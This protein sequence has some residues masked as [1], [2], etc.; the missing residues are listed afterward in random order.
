MGT[1][2]LLRLSECLKALAPF[3][4]MADEFEG[5]APDRL[6]YAISSDGKTF[7][8]TVGHLR[9]ARDAMID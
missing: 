9:A 7:K 8:V 4:E 5:E 2:T 1:Q 6:V 3:A